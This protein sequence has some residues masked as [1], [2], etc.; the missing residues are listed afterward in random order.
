MGDHE[1]EEELGPAAGV[2]IRGPV[3]QRLIAHGLP[4]A[5]AAKG[6]VDE[7]GDAL[8]TGQGQDALFHV[9]VVDGVIDADEV[10]RLAAHHLFEGFV[11]PF[12]GGGDAEM[13]DGAGLLV[14][15]QDGELGGRVADVV[16]LDE[17]D[18]TL[19]D[20]RQR[21]VELG[22]RGLGVGRAAPCGDVEFGGPEKG[23]GQPCVPCHFADHLFRFAAVRRRGV[24]QA[25]ALL[26]QGLQHG[27]QLVGFTIGRGLGDRCRGAQA[28][29]G[30]LFAAAGNGA[31]D[32]RLG[33]QLG[34]RQARAD[35]ERGTGGKAGLEKVAT[36][37]HRAALMAWGGREEA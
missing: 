33:G 20:A 13:A 32:Q 7:H 12:E 8:V 30:K 6:R 1:L 22:A 27:A 31:R 24:D 14:L 25:T 26:V 3:G 18:R 9:A 15:A 29:D 21:G 35:R 37:V 28:H 17:I 5:G 11:L 23:V 36:G 16:H 34:P 4:Q 2:E 10:E 19:A